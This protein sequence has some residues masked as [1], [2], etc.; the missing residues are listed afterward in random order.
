MVTV[1]T[2]RLLESFVILILGTSLLDL[3]LGRY[4]RGHFVPNQVMR[5]A[6]AAGDGCIL[7]IGDSRVEAGIDAGVLEEAAAQR[8]VRTCA[9]NLGIG[10]VGIEGQAIALRSYLEHRSPSIVVLG[11]GPLLPSA[12]PDPA[13]MVGNV[14]I[15]LAWSRAS[16]V[17]AFY[18]SFPFEH[19][20]AGLRFSIARTN[21]LQ[22]YASLVWAR[23]QALQSSFLG[24]GGAAPRNR[25]GLLSDMHALTKSFTTTAQSQLAENQRAWREGPWFE[26]I[27]TMAHEKRAPVLVV[28]VPM[29]TAYRRAV[30]D[31][32]LW[33]S[34]EAWLTSD[35]ARRGDSYLD[36]SAVLGDDRFQDGVH[37]NSAGARAVSL[38]VGEAAVRLLRMRASSGTGP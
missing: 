19:L 10:A 6:L 9:A 32:P 31:T 16:D 33:S 14:A 5:E 11:V 13:E 34:Y 15:E 21:V 12:A 37:P 23:V 18:P 1:A 29:N 20:D 36:L 28:H 38:S 35:L 8:G 2:R 26:A 3:G 27:D 4:V 17:T 7:A 30:N 25:F 22:S 24:T